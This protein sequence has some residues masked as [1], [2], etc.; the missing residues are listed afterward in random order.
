MYE[1]GQQV[2]QK[3]RSVS[4]STKITRAMMQKGL[5]EVNQALAHIKRDRMRHCDEMP[6]Y[7]QPGHLSATE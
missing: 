7:E 4:T 2:P 6:G 5:D 1:E 3:D